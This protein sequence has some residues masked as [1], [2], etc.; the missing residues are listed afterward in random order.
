MDH[1]RRTQYGRLMLMGTVLIIAG[2]EIGCA[3]FANP[4]APDAIPVHRLPPEAFGRPRE[5]ERTIPL[6]LL[7]QEPPKNYLLDAG[8]VLGVYI[9]GILGERGGVPPIIFPGTI[10]YSGQGTPPPPALGYPI[11]VQ[12]NGTINLPLLDPIP[13]AGKTAIDLQTEIAK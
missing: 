10:G 6:T 1:S 5:E 12:D 4:A 7:R 13:V 8:D 2:I 11:P 9:E 3:S